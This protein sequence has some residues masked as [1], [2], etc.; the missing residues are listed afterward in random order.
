MAG[1]MGPASQPTPCNSGL[2]DF[3]SPGTW[4]LPL[5]Q[6]LLFLIP[7]CP[8]SRNM[9]PASQQNAFVFGFLDPWQEHVL[10]FSANSFCFGIPGSLDSR[11]MGSASPPIQFILGFLDFHTPERGPCLSDNSFCFGFPGFPESRNSGPASQPNSSCFGVPGFLLFWD[12]WISGLQEHGP[13]FSADSPC[14]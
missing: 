1:L 6:F 5:S 10:R 8:N 9:G 14:F 11:T 3:R 13:C 12:F 7:G 4:A 2:L